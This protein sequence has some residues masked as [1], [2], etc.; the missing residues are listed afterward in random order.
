[1]PGSPWC[2]FLPAMFKLS[3]SLTQLSK[4]MQSVQ[5]AM[6]LPSPCNLFKSLLH[7]RFTLVLVSFSHVQ[8][9]L[10]QRIQKPRK[11]SRLPCT[12]HCPAIFYRFT[13]C[14]VHPGISSFQP[15]SSF[16]SGLSPA[17]LW[18]EQ[19]SGLLGL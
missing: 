1:M 12:S 10:T 19:C 17:L 3:G 6:H 7:A 14:Q 15:C 5:V 9:L 13:T 8:A 11:A 2:Q 4:S 16:G 18:F